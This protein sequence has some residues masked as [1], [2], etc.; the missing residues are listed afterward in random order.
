MIAGLRQKFAHLT[1]ARGIEMIAKREI[2][3]HAWK[4][5]FHKVQHGANG[6]AYAIR[7]E[8][9]D[10]VWASMPDAFQVTEHQFAALQGLDL[11]ILGAAFWKE[12]VELHRRSIY[13]VQETLAIKHMLHVKHLIV[14]HM[15][16][17]VDVPLY[18][19]QLPDNVEFACD[20][21]EV[22]I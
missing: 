11:L 17:G 8:G 9:R 4:I 15:S 22:N 16:H 18:T 3:L 7:F 5:T 1:P 12:D 2:Q 20:G 10:K 19:S 13:D 21:M 14:T 6:Y